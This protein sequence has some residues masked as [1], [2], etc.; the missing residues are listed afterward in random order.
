[1]GPSTGAH[2]AVRASRGLLATVASD[3]FTARPL[4]CSQESENREVRNGVVQGC[5]L[6]PPA[7]VFCSL[8]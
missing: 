4:L 3:T 2:V 1:M 5:D 8:R 7:S 6:Y